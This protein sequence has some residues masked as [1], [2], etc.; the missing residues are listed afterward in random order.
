MSVFG[1][2]FILTMVYCWGGKVGREARNQAD[3]TC[4]LLG[5]CLS[6]FL[7]DS[8]QSHACRGDDKNKQ[9]HWL[10]ECLKQFFLLRS[11]VKTNPFCSVCL[12]V[13]ASISASWNVLVAPMGCGPAVGMHLPL[14]FLLLFFFCCII[15]QIYVFERIKYI[16]NRDMIREFH[17]SLLIYPFL[18][19]PP[20]IPLHY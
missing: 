20:S 2:L 5:G 1:F 14:W 13:A 3:W 6:E 18:P 19:L 9:G 16:S 7:V 11:L 15:P 8:F 4:F 10:T 12:M 17:F